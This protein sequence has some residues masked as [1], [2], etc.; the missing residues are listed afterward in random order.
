MNIHKK[1]EHKIKKPKT[2]EHG[3]GTQ[4]NFCWPKKSMKLCDLLK[5]SS[6]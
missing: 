2:K 3:L 1:I 5:L 6:F 4:G